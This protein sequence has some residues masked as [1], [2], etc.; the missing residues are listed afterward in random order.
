MYNQE[1]SLT[2]STV[3]A[4]AVGGLAAASYLDAKYHLRR[5]LGSLGREKKREREYVKAGTGSALKLQPSFADLRISR[6]RP[7]VT[8]VYPSRHLQ[9]VLESSRHLVKSG[10]LYLSGIS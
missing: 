1:H 7:V 9:K 2:W 8:L 3:T 4:A 10:H 6:S 5:E